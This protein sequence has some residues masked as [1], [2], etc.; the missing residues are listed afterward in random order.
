MMISNGSFRNL[1]IWT[2]EPVSF[3]LQILFKPSHTP[4]LYSILLSH[5]LLLTFLPC[6][7]L[8]HSHALLAFRGLHFFPYNHLSSPHNLLAP[9]LTHFRPPKELFPRFLCSIFGCWG[10]AFSSAFSSSAQ[11]F[12]IVLTSVPLSFLPG[13]ADKK[14]KVFLGFGSYGEQEAQPASSAPRR[15][16]YQRRLV[17]SQTLVCIIRRSLFGDSIS[18]T[19]LSSTGLLIP[20]GVRQ[21]MVWEYLVQCAQILLRSR[22]NGRCRK[23]ST[24]GNIRLMF[25][26]LGS[27][28]REKPPL[29]LV[30][31]HVVGIS[32]ERRAMAVWS[33]AVVVAIAKSQSDPLHYRD[34]CYPSSDE[35]GVRSL[36]GLLYAEVLIVMQGEE[37]RGTV[38]LTF[39]QNLRLETCFQVL[40][41]YLRNPQANWSFKY[42]G[43][44]LSLHLVR[45]WDTRSQWMFL[46]TCCLWT[47]FATV[48]K[49]TPKKG[50]RKPLADKTND[51]PVSGLT[52]EMSKPQKPSKMEKTPASKLRRGAKTSPTTPGEEVLRTQVSKNTLRGSPG[53]CRL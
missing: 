40:R 1:N 46:T 3:F 17:F 22:W 47:I 33:M 7:H 26:S 9:Y 11:G 15:R 42:L 39:R 10:S 31:Q 24:H 6:T 30:L 51:S 5:H 49:A 12:L 44:C 21:K 8:I 14:V 43:Q 13:G 38:I 45:F 34:Q 48:R 37:A 53:H 2:G 36:P 28:L 16:S 27:Y 25:L 20:S 19:R 18:W 29:L 23:R 52:P 32:L 4:R 35:F 50:S 41:P